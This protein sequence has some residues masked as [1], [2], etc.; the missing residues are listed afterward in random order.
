MVSTK[1]IS[2]L[3]SWEKYYKKPI[4]AVKDLASGFPYPIKN[5]N[6]NS[7]FVEGGLF[8]H[9]CDNLPDITSTMCVFISV[10]YK[11]IDS[12]EKVYCF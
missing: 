7:N 6:T 10:N 3:Q 11:S 5:K 12:S 2:S 4:K 8:A 1:H 9:R